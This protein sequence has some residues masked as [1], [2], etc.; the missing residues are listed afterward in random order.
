MVKLK[1]AE[2]L[3]ESSFAEVRATMEEEFKSA[4]RDSQYTHTQG[5]IEL[6]HIGKDGQLRWCEVTS[7]FLRDDRATIVGILGVTRD[8]S[9]RKQ[10]E[11]TV[12]QSEQRF[13]G[14]AERSFDAIF[15]ADE[16]GN[17]SYLSSAVERILGY[18]SEEMVHRH[19]CEFLVP[20]EIPRVQRLFGEALQGAFTE[21]LS[22]EAIRKNGTH[23]H[24]EVS[25]SRILDRDRLVGLQGLIRDV[26]ERKRAEDALRK[27]QHLL[28]QL[29]EVQE[30]ER[31]LISYEIH[32]GLA[33]RIFGAQML[34]QGVE[35]Q[36]E[37]LPDDARERFGQALQ[38]LNHGGKEARALISQLRPPILDESG[39]LAAI[40]YLVAEQSALAAVKVGF[41]KEGRFEGLPTALQ[42]IIFRI[43]QEGLAN[44]CRHSQSDRVHVELARHDGT[45]RVEVRDWGRGFDPSNVK[46][47]SFGLEGMRER[48]RL[49]GGKTTIDS[50][51][52]MGTRITVELPDVD[53]QSA[54]TSVHSDE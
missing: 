33:Q 20:S 53:I 27:E 14:I 19:F 32:D 16:E 39:I 30:R 34:L 1:P 38:L 8:V 4:L 10:A 45:I 44:A 15:T 51:P 54:I 42:A 11:E 26:T 24:L 22:I 18:R 37:T 52:G 9:D 47:N 28:R 48:A 43:V 12:R 50:A 29:L 2:I 7:R 40:D 25:H 3:T 35:P 41:R 46:E 31:R 23:A 21:V 13:R 5:S 49:F 6:A 17:F 36:I